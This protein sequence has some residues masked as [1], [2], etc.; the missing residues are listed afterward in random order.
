MM[1]F[2]RMAQLYPNKGSCKN[3]S[4]IKHRHF[5]MVIPIFFYNHPRPKGV[6]WS[7]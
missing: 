2:V 4:E 3:K 6:E 5:V 1:N 7:D